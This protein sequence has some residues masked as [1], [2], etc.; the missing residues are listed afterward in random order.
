MSAATAQAT[1]TTT[2]GVTALYGGTRTTIQTCNAVRAHDWNTV[3]FN[4]G[5]LLGG[6]VVGV[7]GGGRVMAEGIMGGPSPAPNTW[8]PIV[9]L[10][11]EINKGYQWNYPNGSVPSWLATGPTPASAGAS[12]AFTASGLISP[13]PALNGSQSK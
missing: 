8:N 13:N 1:V 2:V 4:T 12:A 7:S 10:T 5:N 3:A 11:Y 9:I 6:S